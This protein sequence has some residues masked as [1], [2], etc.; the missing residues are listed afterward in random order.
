LS[1][2][3][4]FSSKEIYTIMEK[5][6]IEIENEI[7]SNGNIL[8]IL[9]NDEKENNEQLTSLLNELKD[10]IEWFFNYIKF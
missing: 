4:T 2:K 6:R 10:I 3:I 9:L 1:L 8:S 7:F 5:I